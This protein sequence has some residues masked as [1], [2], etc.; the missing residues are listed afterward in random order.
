MTSTGGSPE[1][2]VAATLERLGVGRGDGILA[3]LSGGP[4]SMA[5]VHILCGLREKLEIE[6]CCAYLDHG[7]RDAPEREAEGRA[8]R[9]F[10]K[11][12]ELE[13]L[14]GEIAP[15]S[16]SHEARESGRSLEDLAR[17]DRYAFLHDRA[18]GTSATWIATGHTSDDN[19]ETVLMRVL[20][21]SDVFGL[22]GI[23]P[24]RDRVIRPLI[25]VSRAEAHAYV[26]AA[27]LTPVV[28]STNRSDRYLRNR[29]RSAILP[30][31]EEVLPGARDNVLRLAA[32]MRVHCEFVAESAAA[33]SWRPGG[34]GLESEWEP[35]ARAHGV[36]RMASVYS[37]LDTLAIED[38]DRGR[39]FSYGLLRPIL[40]LGQIGRNQT[41]VEGSGYTLARR[42]NLVL[43]ERD[44]VHGG[45][46]GYLVCVHGDGVYHVPEAGLRVVVSSTDEGPGRVW[47]DVQ[48]R[49]FIVRS[50]HTGDRIRIHSGYKSL[51]SMY[52]EWKVPLDRRGLLPVVVEGSEVLCVL[53]GVLGY[54]DR[55]REPAHPGHSSH[56]GA[57]VRCDFLAGR[58]SMIEVEAT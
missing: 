37:A 30:V 58:G 8:V 41:I 51:K 22:R 36:V 48:R 7:I 35:F 12:L 14:T 57:Y 45:K 20:Q 38:G 6:V 40:H 53:G 34:H 50:W 2:R 16:L 47:V 5:M 55:L 10:A 15:G 28:D 23:P 56:G 42:G 13:L 44:V 3:A 1:Y 21:G 24:R 54:V 27:G 19:L 46:S 4:D 18:E 25:D 11:T 43:L 39:R 33:I 26:R 52:N 49:P 32:K 9:D 17:R 31:I 29:V